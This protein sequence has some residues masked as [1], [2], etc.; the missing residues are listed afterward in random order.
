[1]FKFKPISILFEA[2]AKPALSNQFPG[3]SSLLE[4]SLQTHKLQK[5]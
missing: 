3:L 1:M 5:Q 4:K 2:N